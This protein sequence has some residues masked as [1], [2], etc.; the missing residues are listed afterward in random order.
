M[1]DTFNL[2]DNATLQQIIDGFPSALCIIDRDRLSLR[3]ANKKFR[4]YYGHSLPGEPGCLESFL[5]LLTPADHLRFRNQLSRLHAEQQPQ[6]GFVLYNILHANGSKMPSFVRASHFEGANGEQ[7]CYVTIAPD[8]GT[9]KMPILSND[10]SDLFLQQ[11]KDEHF[12]TFEWMIAEDKVY[13]SPGIY[14]IYEVEENNTEFSRNF[15]TWFMHPADREKSE[16]I[17]KKAMATGETIELEYRIITARRNTKV[18][19]ALGK[20]IDNWDGRPLKFIGSVRDITERKEIEENLR[21]KV[22]ELNDTNR[23][24]E[25]FA[26][27]ASHDMQEPLRKI[28]TFSS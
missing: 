17:L 5:D 16:K 11:F 28:T 13:W 6:S 26:Y 7:Q 8:Y 12:G 15:V 19:H 25:E 10:T 4:D 24:L 20:R 1:T 27:I 14:K 18:I 23:E 22:K 2:N 9:F 3:Y 21:N